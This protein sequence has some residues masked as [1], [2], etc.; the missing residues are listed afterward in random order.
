MENNI[1]SFLTEF[2]NTLYILD[3]YVGCHIQV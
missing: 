1:Q 2:I 3:L